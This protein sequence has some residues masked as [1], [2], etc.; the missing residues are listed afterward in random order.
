MAKMNKEIKNAIV[1]T[2]ENAMSYEEIKKAY[3]EYVTEFK[4]NKSAMTFING[5]FIKYV[6]EVK[7]IHVNAKGETYQKDPKET[8]EEFMTLI[9]ELIGMDGIT[10][11]ACG[12]WLWVSGATKAN[13]D[14]LKAC[15]FRYAAKKQKWY[16]APEG[17][18]HYKG[19]KTWTMEQIRTAYGSHVVE[20]ADEIEETA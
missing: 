9:D 2:F 12:T 16:K 17:S 18:K 10:V 4:G 13:K 7:D 14:A 6:E 1:K 8:T 11:E 3:V 5:A 20:S 19:K 15:G